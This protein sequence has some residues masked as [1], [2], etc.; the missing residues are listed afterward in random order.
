DLSGHT[1]KNRPRLFGLKPA[2][3][4]VSWLGYP[5]TTGISAID[6]LVMDPSTAPPGAEAWVT[7]AL[8]RLPHG[9]FCYSP[10]SYAPEVATPPPRPVTFG[11]FNNTAKLGPEVVRLWAR[12]LDAAP[13]SRLLLKWKHLADPGVRQRV[14]DAFLSA[15]VGADRLELRGLSPHAEM[16]AE[17]ADVDIALDP[18]P[19]CGGL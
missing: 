2:P 14:A 5:G 7:E 9:R 6:Y 15:G 12:V 3:V 17:Y 16:L 11:S 8:V 18:F 1:D 4:Q 13:G 19:F 10:P